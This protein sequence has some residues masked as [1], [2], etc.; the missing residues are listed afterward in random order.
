M[1]VLVFVI[2]TLIE[3]QAFSSNNGLVQNSWILVLC[4][5][6]TL[7]VFQDVAHKIDAAGS[8]GNCQSPKIRNYCT[9]PKPFQKKSYLIS[10]SSRFLN[11]LHEFGMK[12][13][14]KI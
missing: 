1:L 13:V 14:E 12:T 5:T 8:K 11:S 4:V 10:V 9:A 7:V 3:F 6:G 2:G